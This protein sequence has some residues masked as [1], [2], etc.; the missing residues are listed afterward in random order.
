MG[1]PE[2]WRKLD[3]LA[4]IY[5][6][7]QGAIPSL[8]LKSFRDGQQ[9]V[10]FLEQFRLRSGGKSQELGELL[11]NDFGLG[12]KTIQTYDEDA[13]SVQFQ[14]RELSRLDDLR[15]ALGEWL[16]RNAIS[17]ELPQIDLIPR[18][19]LGRVRDRFPIS[20]TP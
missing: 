13:G 19:G 6:S 7:D 4:V 17:D 8:R 10:E 14:E 20:I 15:F 5:P 12:G 11:L 18:Q 1:T 16:S 3:P 9:L 2:S